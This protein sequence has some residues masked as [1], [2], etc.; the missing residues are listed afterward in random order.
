MRTALVISARTVAF[1]YASAGFVYC[2]RRQYVRGTAY[3]ATACYFMLAAE[4]FV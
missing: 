3:I 1:V 4:A 2:W